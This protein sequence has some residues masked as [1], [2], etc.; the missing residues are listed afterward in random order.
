MMKNKKVIPFPVNKP[1]KVTFKS[2]EQI[3]N[4]NRMRREAILKGFSKNNHHR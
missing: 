1:K 2:Q 4:E 3:T